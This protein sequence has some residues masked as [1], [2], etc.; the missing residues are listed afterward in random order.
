MKILERNSQKLPLHTRTLQAALPWYCDPL[1]GV[2]GVFLAGSRAPVAAATLF[3]FTCPWHG[4]GL[5]NPL[6]QVDVRHNA[7]ECAGWKRTGKKL[8]SSVNDVNVV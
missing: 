4:Q 5:Q 8:F 6:R 2:V 1:W 3:C 7:C